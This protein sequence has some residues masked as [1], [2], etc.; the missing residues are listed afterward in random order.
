MYTSYLEALCK[1]DNTFTFLFLKY[2]FSYTEIN[3]IF[4]LFPEGDE[5]GVMDSLL[6]ALQSGAAFRDRR[7]RTPRPQGK[8]LSKNFQSLTKCAKDVLL[9]FTKSFC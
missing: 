7:K 3:I 2:D 5:T 9:R 6:E 8:M 1:L 4:L